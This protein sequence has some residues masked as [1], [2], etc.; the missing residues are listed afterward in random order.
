MECNLINDQNAKHF[1]L[2]KHAE[3]SIPSAGKC[4]DN[5]QKKNWEQKNKLR[6]AKISG[7]ST[8]KLMGHIFCVHEEYNFV[9]QYQFYFIN[10]R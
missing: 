8:S 5:K 6:K 10:E 3:E 1:Y 9:T 2:M 7:N 4:P